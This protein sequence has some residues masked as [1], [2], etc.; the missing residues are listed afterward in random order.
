MAKMASSSTPPYGSRQVSAAE[1]K[2][3][4]GRVLERAIAGET[5]AITKY[6]VV[7]AVMLSVEE[8]ESLS[9][10][11]TPR[12]NLLTEQFD[13]M[14]ARMQGD[15]ARGRMAEAFNASPKAMGDAAVRVARGKRAARV[16]A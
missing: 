2:N 8:Y 13:E 14:L 12:L 6:G 9:H 7:R 10:S 15:E 16:L 3:E 1:A 5:V 11:P 4:F